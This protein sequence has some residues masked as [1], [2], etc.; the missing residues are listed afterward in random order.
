LVGVGILPGIPADV[1]LRVELYAYVPK[2]C[3]F[4]S[5]CSKEKQSKNRR[6][7]RVA[8]LNF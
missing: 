8:Q 2:V 3:R 7:Q 4:L 1:Y 5:L 6:T